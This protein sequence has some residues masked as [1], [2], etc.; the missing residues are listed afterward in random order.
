MD[1]HLHMEYHHTPLHYKFDVQCWAMLLAQVTGSSHFWCPVAF[2]FVQTASLD[3]ENLAKLPKT[4][5][6]DGICG[7]SV[8]DDMRL[9]NQVPQWSRPVQTPRKLIAFIGRYE[10]LKTMICE[11]GQTQKVDIHHIQYP[12]VVVRLAV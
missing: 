7:N 5:G 10:L 4:A 8:K 11:D 12:A 2:Y 9:S 6:T 1:E 3:H